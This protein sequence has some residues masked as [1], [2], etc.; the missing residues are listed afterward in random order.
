MDYNNYI[1]ARVCIKEKKKKKNS[2]GVISHIY[3]HLKNH[4][5][6]FHHI[7]VYLVII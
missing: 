1:Q 2:L 6:I 4:L 5:F 3:A 7:L